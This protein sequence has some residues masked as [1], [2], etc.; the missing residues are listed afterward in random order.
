MN[1]ALLVANSNFGART[2]TGWL[3]CS[4]CATLIHCASLRQKKRSSENCRLD[5]IEQV[6]SCFVLRFHVLH[7]RIYLR[8]SAAWS[9]LTS[10]N[11]SRRRASKNFSERI[12]SR[13]KDTI[14]TF[15]LANNKCQDSAKILTPSVELQTLF[16]LSKITTWPTSWILR[17][18]SDEK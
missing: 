15:L 17:A 11:E 8:G 5:W 10:C 2:T 6:L 1:T 4:S 13:F 18:K 12:I 16:L 7:S 9:E 3:Q 14:Q